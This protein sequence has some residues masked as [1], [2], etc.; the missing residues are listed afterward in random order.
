MVKAAIKRYAFLG[1]D[2]FKN[3]LRLGMV[4]FYSGKQVNY[5]RQNFNGGTLMTVGT[6]EKRTR[7]DLNHG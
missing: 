5:E 4:M 6:K 7:T 2:I 1:T 3:H